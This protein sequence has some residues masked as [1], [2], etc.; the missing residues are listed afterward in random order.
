MT[1]EQFTKVQDLTKEIEELILLFQIST[2]KSP[3]EWERY[4]ISGYHEILK[5][6]SAICDH[7]DPTGYPTLD[8]NVQF[9]YLRQCKYCRLLLQM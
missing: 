4:K 8:P 7:V 5:Q 3:Y 9:S 2:G 1:T 6:I